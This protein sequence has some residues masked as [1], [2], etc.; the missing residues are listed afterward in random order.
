LKRLGDIL[1]DTKIHCYAWV[2]M[3]NHVHLLLKTGLTPIAMVI[4]RLLTGYAVSFNRRYRRH[5]QMFQ[6]RYSSFLCEDNVY[7]KE[8]VRYLHINPIKA[9]MVKGVKELKTYPYSGHSV[10]MYKAKCD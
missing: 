3:T 1:P 6:N 5:G 9:K 2:L 10:L 7:L 8:L 4:R